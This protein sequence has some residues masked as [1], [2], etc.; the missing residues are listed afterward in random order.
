MNHKKPIVPRK[1]INWKKP[2][3]ELEH[4][5]LTM[6]LWQDIWLNNYKHK[7]YSKYYKYVKKFFGDCPVCQY[8]PNCNKCCL[9]FKNVACMNNKHPY[10]KWSNTDCD[11]ERK[12]YAYCIYK[13]LY[14]KLSH[15]NLERR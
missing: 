10:Y 6:L 11:G 9:L 13:K 1:D 5:Y 8:H 4:I 7:S 3:T 14:Y 2:E 15:L 12:F